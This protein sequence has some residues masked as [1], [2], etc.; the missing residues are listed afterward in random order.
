VSSKVCLEPFLCLLLERLV[1]VL[2]A[3]HLTMCC[4]IRR[5]K[6]TRSQVGR[7]GSS[8]FSLKSFLCVYRLHLEVQT[9]DIAL[10]SRILDCEYLFNEFLD[11]IFHHSSDCCSLE[12]TSHRKEIGSPGCRRRAVARLSSHR[13][14]AGT[15]TVRWG[16]GKNPIPRSKAPTS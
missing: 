11:L 3:R 6:L 9:Q 14:R 16:D 4:P 8:Q 12:S 2:C 10:P 13:G 1:G 7:G 5:R 15:R